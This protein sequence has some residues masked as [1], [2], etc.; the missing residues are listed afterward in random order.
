MKSIVI[1]G[2]FQGGALA[3]ILSENISFCSDYSIEKM[4]PVHELTIEDMEKVL[5]AVQHADIFLYQHV[6]EL[7]GRPSS[8]SSDFLLQQLKPSACSVSFPSIYF[9][10]YF[11]QLGTMNGIV[12]TLNLVHDYIIAYCY[13]IGLHEEQVVSLIQHDDLFSAELSRNLAER[14]IA[15]LRQRET[16]C[17]VDIC[18]SDYIEENYQRYKLF[19]Q[20]NHPRRIL[21]KYL[22]E[23]VLERL[24]VEDS[25]IELDGIGY[26]D[27]IST[28]VYRSVYDGLGLEFEENFE[29][30]NTFQSV[31][32]AQ[33]DVVKGFFD[34]YKR[35]DSL[36]LQKYIHKFKPFV[37]KLVDK[38]IL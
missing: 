32:V 27:R 4:K 13:A 15:N 30:Y 7:P 18:L 9:D 25:H 26:L 14:S 29:L 10:G 28:P 2:N 8:F 35:I 5:L 16:A 3:Q 12:G 33:N 23:K 38:A 24:E 1:Y 6:A 22:G 17:C 37:P 21:F 36:E 19:N 20:F 34:C 31:A 11:P